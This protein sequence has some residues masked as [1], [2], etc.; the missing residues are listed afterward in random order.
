MASSHCAT[1]QATEITPAAIAS[2]IQVFARVLQDRFEQQTVESSSDGPQLSALGVADVVVKL[3]GEAVVDE[4]V[5]DT[6]LSAG[7][8]AVDSRLEERRH[9]GRRV[10][11]GD[12][13]VDGVCNKPAVVTNSSD[14]KVGDV[15][16]RVTVT[17]R[18]IQVRCS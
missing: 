12:L 8:V 6:G 5:H 2:V 9:R 1:Y 13:Q 15:T 11:D 7:L 18:S 4:A 3:A 17:S 10:D 14:D 16:P